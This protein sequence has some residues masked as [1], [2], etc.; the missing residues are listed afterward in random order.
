MNQTKSSTIVGVIAIFTAFLWL[1]PSVGRAQGG[2]PFELLQSQIADLTAVAGLGEPVTLNVNCPAN[3][4]ADALAQVVFKPGSTL[5]VSGTCDERVLIRETVNNITLDGGRGLLG[6]PPGATVN[7]F[8]IRGREITIKGFK[9]TAPG[10]SGILVRRGGTVKIDSN[11]IE[12]NSNGINV[13]QQSFA[14]IINNL[15]ISNERSGIVVSEGSGARIGFLSVPTV[16]IAPND[17][18][19]NDV[20]IRVQNLATARIVGNNIKD[21]V[22]D[23]IRV[24]SVAQARIAGNFIDGNGSDGMDVRENSGVNL[25][26]DADSSTENPLD[27][28]NTGANDKRGVRC[29]TGP[30]VSGEMGTLD[31]KDYADDGTCIENLDDVP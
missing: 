10:R 11:R 2:Q 13:G 6:S 3:T 7:G 1:Q 23:G 14:R 8:N 30:Y 4:I 27:D 31:G 28:T 9:I 24:Q 17:I 22:G 21:N 20:G 25:G 29:S 26:T 5:L 18:V 12:D 19:D 16:V 15:I